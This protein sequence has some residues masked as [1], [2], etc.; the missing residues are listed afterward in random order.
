V[1][2]LMGRYGVAQGGSRC[3]RGDP[4]GG[5]VSG[6]DVVA[7]E[8]GGVSKGMWLLKGGCGGTGSCGAR[9]DMRRLSGGCSGSRRDVVAQKRM[10][11]YKGRRGGSL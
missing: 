2:W 5:V 9:G 3:S 1:M 11:W 10:Q 8:V 4:G 7:Q 6:G